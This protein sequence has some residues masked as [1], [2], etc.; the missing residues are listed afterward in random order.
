MRERRGKEGE[1]SEGDRNR[2]ESSWHNGRLNG[3]KGH[4]KIRGMLAAFTEGFHGPKNLTRSSSV[5]CRFHALLVEPPARTITLSRAATPAILAI[6][7][8]T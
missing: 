4:E 6:S 2:R 5:V 8:G 3:T 1:R 7:D